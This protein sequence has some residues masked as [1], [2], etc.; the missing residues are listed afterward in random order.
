MALTVRIGLCSDRLVIQHDGCEAEDIFPIGSAVQILCQKGE[1][2]IFTGC[3]SGTHFHKSPD[4][5]PMSRVISFSKCDKHDYI[6]ELEYPQFLV[7][8]VELIAEGTDLWKVVL[9]PVYQMPWN[10]KPMSLDEEGLI[11][12]F[13]KGMNSRMASAVR[14][15]VSIRKV[16]DMRPSWSQGLVTGAAWM[17]LINGELE[18][19]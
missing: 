17:A 3:E 10:H 4:N 5:S 14:R 8:N 7:D 19:A 15:G 2:Y 1:I 11:A 9:P 16:I 12:L 6:E 13:I 18:A